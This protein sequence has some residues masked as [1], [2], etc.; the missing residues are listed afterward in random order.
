MHFKVTGPLLGE[1]N[2]FVTNLPHE[3]IDL[4][5]LT[6]P[7]QCMPTRSP[8]QDIQKNRFNL[9]VSAYSDN[10]GFHQLKK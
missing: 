2:F 4:T 9:V 7:T 10:Q 6:K 1:L 3:L 5:Q 8:G